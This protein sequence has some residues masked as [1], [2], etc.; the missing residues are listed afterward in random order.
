MKHS[1]LLTSALTVLL[2]S[3]L[4]VQAKNGESGNDPNNIDDN[5]SASDM[6]NLN[7]EDLASKQSSKQAADIT[8]EALESIK[9]SAPIVYTPE[10]YQ[11]GAT[12]NQLLD[13]WLGVKNGINSSGISVKN[14]TF[15]Y[16]GGSQQAKVLT[17]ASI[18][19]QFL[20]TLN[21]TA[22]YG[23]LLTTGSANFSNTNTSSGFS[24]V[25]GTGSNYYVSAISNQNTYDANVLKF[26]FTVA[27]GV[28][29]VSTQFLFAS[30]EYPEW[31]GLFKDGFAFVVDGINYA[32]FD[33]THFVTLSD[34]GLST[35]ANP[36]ISEGSNHFFFDNRPDANGTQVAPFEYDGYSQLLTATGLLQD[37]LAVHTLEVAIAD[38][39]DSVWDSAVFLSQLRAFNDT[40]APQLS[41]ASFGLLASAV[42]EPSS[43]SLLFA[44]VLLMLGMMTR[45]Q[46]SLT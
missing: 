1:F 32:K 6:I 46:K 33:E 14:E 34:S 26:A 39:N 29:S 8:P 43:S 38:S 21:P 17:D 10:I 30:E 5:P 45:H 12:G 24:N 22:G 18:E 19:G 27:P 2:A 11:P 16:V 36:I 13:A 3:S 9:P 25:T 35:L 37:G 23:A 28:N 31:T 20:Y 40:N 4:S 41:A 15:Q 44:G 42:P 7:P